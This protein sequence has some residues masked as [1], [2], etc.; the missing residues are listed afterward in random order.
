MCLF[1][2]ALELGLTFAQSPGDTKIVDSWL[3]GDSRWQRRSW[4]TLSITLLVLSILVN[5]WLKLNPIE[6]HHGARWRQIKR[7]AL[8]LEASADGL[9]HNMGKTT[10]SR[11]SPTLEPVYDLKIHR[12]NLPVFVMKGAACLQTFC[13]RVKLLPL[14][15]QGAQHVSFH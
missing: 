12:I 3:S 7:F 5:V 8:Q 14:L 11:A 1:V 15:G 2:A 13:A 10:P 9:D 4:Y 6:S